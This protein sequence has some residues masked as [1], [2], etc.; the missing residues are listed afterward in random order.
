M[1][2]LDL[3]QRSVEI[4]RIRIGATVKASNG[5]MRPTK[6]DAFR[7][8][9]NSP[10]AAAG[11][12]EQFGGEVRP[13]VGGTQAFEVFTTTTSMDVMV[14]AGELALSQWYE[15]WS[16]GGCQ[17]RCD[18]RIEQLSGGPCQC[19]ADI[20]Q[21][22]VL[23][24]KGEACKPTTRVS[25]ILPDLQGLGVW[26]HESKGYNAAQ[27]LGATAE[28]L[29]RAREGGAIIPASM[30][31]E[32]RES[33]TGTE[34]HKFAVVVL[35]VAATLRELVEG[36]V[37]GTVAQALPPAPSSVKALEAPK[38]PGQVLDGTPGSGP[39]RSRAKAGSVDVE[40]APTA[41][42]G[43]AEDPVLAIAKT[44]L[45]C[46]DLKDLEGIALHVKHEGIDSELVPDA[47]GV[48]DTLWNVIIARRDALAG[49]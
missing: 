47:R 40:E 20:E 48:L 46:S 6:L 10:G 42:A 41:P 38:T 4:G 45:A 8:T 9:T 19:P 13:W 36:T 2:L 5:K 43:P 23:A 30:R 3:Q 7:F 29:A 49:G 15:M 1:P 18:A 16:G 37:G 34:T 32:Q 27:E 11:V 21:R 24:A 14:P 44:V 31:L 12:A 22:M 17:R 39:A 28:F 25:V 33:K 35:D 26:R